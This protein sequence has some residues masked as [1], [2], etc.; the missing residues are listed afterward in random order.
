MPPTPTVRGLVEVGGGSYTETTLWASLS[1]G[2]SVLFFLSSTSPSFLLPLL[3]QFS[4]H[5]PLQTYCWQY[6][7]IFYQF[8]FC[9]YFSWITVVLGLYHFDVRCWYFC[10]F[11]KWFLIVSNVSRTWLTAANS[12]FIDDHF[13]SKCGQEYSDHNIH[14]TV[15]QPKNWQLYKWFSCLLSL[16]LNSVFKNKKYQKASEQLLHCLS[17]NHI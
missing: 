3:P 5:L 12:K 14:I 11:G 6:F 8:T 15:P 13:C 16:Q 9:R 4:A 2:V 7:N 17:S 10:Q 1:V